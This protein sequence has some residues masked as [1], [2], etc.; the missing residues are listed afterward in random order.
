MKDHD[1][2]ARILRKSREKPVFLLSELYPAEKL[3]ES[4][5]RRIETALIRLRSFGLVTEKK[6]PD[7]LITRDASGPFVLNEKKRQNIADYLKRPEISDKIQVLT[8][9]YI[10]K[11]TG[12]EWQDPLTLERIRSAVMAQKGEYWHEGAG[13]RVR[14]DKGYQV[15]AYLAYQFPVYYAQFEHIL[16]MLTGMELLPEHM[17]VLDAGSGP[18][19]TTLAIMD[20]L[21]RAGHGTA[22]ISALELSGEQREAYT[23]L[24][25]G[26]AEG[27][28]SVIVYPAIEGDIRNPDT[29]GL[30]RNIDLLVFQNVLNELSALT[31]TERAG[32][33]AG[34]ADVLSPTG[35]ILIVEPADM[36]N[37]VGLRE[38]ACELSRK[39]GFS[40]ISPCLPGAT[41]RCRPERCWSFVEK[42]PVVPT[43]LMD[44]IADHPE[45]YRFRNTDIKFSFA[46]LKKGPWHDGADH[47]P[48]DRKTALL[49]G[50]SRHVGKK[51]NACGAVMSGDLGNIRTHLWKLCDG[52]PQKPVYLV[53][54]SHNTAPGNNVLGTV[55]YGGSI[56]LTGVLVRYN[57]RYDSYNL[58][59]TRDTRVAILG[60][61][62]KK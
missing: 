61:G 9:E 39:S 7:C 26:A 49:S 3:G 18:G 44:A 47:L 15:F 11:K 25:S 21:D 58:L 56:R 54:P 34:F 13:K 27:K 59:V 31:A 23:F 62:E 38:L 33:V 41:R 5:R 37:S 45:Y 2:P 12:K 53:L 20:F 36:A 24:T 22:E 51:I 28:K 60:T 43:R 50:L 30:P 16:L 57:P 48:C 52:S 6:G 29:A 1:I 42:T 19:A 46:V 17:A 10:R 32:L 35:V 55:P 14:Y 8:A 4:D 40:V